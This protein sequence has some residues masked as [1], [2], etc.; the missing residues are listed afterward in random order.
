MWVGNHIGNPSNDFYCVTDRNF[1]WP[2]VWRTNLGGDFKIPSG[3]IFTADVA[4]TKDVNAMMVRNYKLGKPTGT[5]NSGFG[6]KRKI[7]TGCL[8]Y[9]QFRLKP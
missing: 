4:Y 6:D 1:K 5:L 7:Y 3:T 9:K 8:I 2:Q